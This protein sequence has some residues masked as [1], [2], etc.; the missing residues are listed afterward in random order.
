MIENPY[1]LVG[2]LA[3]LLVKLII[4]LLS[5]FMQK[6]V[7]PKHSFLPYL[8]VSRAY[9]SNQTTWMSINLTRMHDKRVHIKITI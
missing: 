9:K 7:W 1:I 8:D 5:L 3:Y 6:Q 2:S 4:K